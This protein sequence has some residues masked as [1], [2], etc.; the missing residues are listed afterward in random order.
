MYMQ[1]LLVPS[2][3]K[4]LGLL[5]TSSSN[6][7]QHALPHLCETF[8]LVHSQCCCPRG[9]HPL[10]A[11][12]SVHSE[13]LPQHLVRAVMLKGSSKSVLSYVPNNED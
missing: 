2:L 10:S 3:N 11:S 7:H 9:G 12:T 1:Q 8:S 5:A 13:L 6:I 4:Q